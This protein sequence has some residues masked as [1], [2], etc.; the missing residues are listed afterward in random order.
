MKL[1]EYQAKSLLQQAGLPVPLGIPILA[2]REISAAVK[3]LP[4][5]PWAVKAQVHTG[6][7]GKAG[8]ILMA[9]KPVDVE[10]AAKKLFGKTLV[11][12]QTGPEGIV[13]QKLYVEQAQQVERELYLACVLDRSKGY[14]VVMA[15]TQGGMEIEELASTK[16][17]AII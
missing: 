11:T 6:G 5:G 1:H 13:I 2:E 10:A 15:S 16:P 14:P 17:E 9:Q 4:A 8:G 3:K 7:R 12:H